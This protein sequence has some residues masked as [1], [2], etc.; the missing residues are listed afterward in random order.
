MSRRVTVTVNYGRSKKINVHGKWFYPGGRIR[1]SLHYL[2]ANPDESETIYF[3][4]GLSTGASISLA[5][6]ECVVCC[7]SKGGFLVVAP[8]L[9]KK[10]PEKRFIIC[11]D[12]D[13]KNDQENDARKAIER[14]AVAVGGI[15]VFPKIENGTDFNDVHC[16][17]G[18][19]EVKKQ[20][21]V[22]PTVIEVD[23][24]FV[25]DAEY[26]DENPKTGKRLATIENL[27]EMLRRLGIIVRY[28]IIH[29]KI[30]FLIP[31]SQSTI[32][33]QANAALAE[34]SSWC[35]RCLIP[36]KNIKGALLKIADS[37][38]YNP[39]A[40]WIQSKPWD[41]ESRLQEFLDTVKSTNEPL[42]E[43]LIRKWLISCIA[44]I[45]EPEGISA[46]GVLVF[47]GDQYLGK[48]MWFKQ[49]APSHLRVLGEGKFL[50]PDDKDSVFPVVSNWIVELGELDATFRKADISQLKA[51]LT[52]DRDVLRRPYAELDSEF[53]R[54][55]VFFGSVNESDYL[56]DPTGNRR[57][58]TIDCEKIDCNH[59]VDMQQL[60]SE[61]YELYKSGEKWILDAEEMKLLNEHNNQF[62]SV[63]SVEERIA[64]KIRWEP[65]DYLVECHLS[66]T[67]ICQEIGILNPSNGECRAAG[68]FARKKTLQPIKNVHGISKFV[69][70]IPSRIN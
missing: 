64:E 69:C 28:N 46:H 29:K 52:K 3:A 49:L 54:R 48:T 57:F 9:R 4:E 45:F 10:Y 5:T 42:K 17:F 43:K 56:K 34:I 60:W 58:W 59:K 39:L 18:I 22:L 23:P 41:G 70:Y 66:A 36:S 53:P 67:Q 6:G 37:N 1:G 13:K 40:I 25:V 20:L 15:A 61:I 7:F 2:G 55:T 14:I 27:R 30:E 35:E 21:S 24:T 16:Q 11:G 26:P 50:K 12:D 47:R 33:N 51:F 44:A 32:D 62:Q 38:A 63:E 65:R 19:E 8:A 68:R 31:N